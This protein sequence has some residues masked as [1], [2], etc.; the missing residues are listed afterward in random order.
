[1]VITVMVPSVAWTLRN[2]SS[3]LAKLSV[4]LSLSPTPPTPL[5]IISS[6]GT[7][8]WL[9]SCISSLPGDSLFGSWPQGHDLLGTISLLQSEGWYCLPGCCILA[10]HLPP[11]E[12]METE[13][14]WVRWL[15]SDRENPECHTKRCWLLEACV[16]HVFSRLSYSFKAS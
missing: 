15:G 16:I 1:M 4:C 14:L 3:P 6:Q 13:T 5:L 10:S 12:M 11:Q 9:P 2:S 7:P 8:L